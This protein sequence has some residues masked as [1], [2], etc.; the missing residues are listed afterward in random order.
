MIIIAIIVVIIVIIIIVIIIVILIVFR[1]CETAGAGPIH[2][3]ACALLHDHGCFLLFVQCRW[4][5]TCMGLTF[6]RPAATRNRIWDSR[7]E[8]PDVVEL[9][10]A[11]AL[12][13]R[14]VAF[15][16]TQKPRM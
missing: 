2:V 14:M 9:G 16:R 4:P 5:F 7:I 12:E 6:A 11:R 15:V 3:R 8:G 1:R 10:T 13:P